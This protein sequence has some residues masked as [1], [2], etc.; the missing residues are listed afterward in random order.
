MIHD[1]LLLWYN[2]IDT[3]GFGPTIW[4]LYIAFA[5]HESMRTGPIPLTSVSKLLKCYKPSYILIKQ[6]IY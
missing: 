3:V 1:E 2:K 4:L 6:N 5:P